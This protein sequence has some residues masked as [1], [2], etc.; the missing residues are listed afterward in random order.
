MTPM[1]TDGVYVIQRV[2]ES[3][4]HTTHQVSLWLIMSVTSQLTGPL[5]HLFA[6][7]PF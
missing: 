2:G 4:P 1:Q 6:K 3:Q 5:A 7:L